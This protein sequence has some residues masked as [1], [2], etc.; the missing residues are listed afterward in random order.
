VIDIA[1]D[2]P[3]FDI[4]AGAFCLRQAALHFPP[5]SIHV[6]VIDP[7]VG[8]E[9]HPVVVESGGHYFIGPDNG[10]FSWVAPT[11]DAAYAITNPAFMRETVSATFHGRDIFAAAAGALAAGARPEQ[12]GP[13]VRL[14]P[15]AGAPPSARVCASDEGGGDIRR[16]EGYVVYI[17]RFGNAI[18]NCPAELVP[19]AARVEVFGTGEPADAPLVIERISR[20]FG[21]VP[22]GRPVAYIGSA[23]TV[24][25]AVREGSAARI[26]GLEKGAPIALHSTKDN[27]REA[28]QG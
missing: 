19:D 21:E 14:A 12:A 25:I 22:P 23:E 11:P 1:H 24:E 13:P 18:S 27:Q 10:V 17:D 8:T 2:I 26:L 9:R 15:L 5:G 16:V 20:T 28:I 6:A 4:A 3:E 7:G